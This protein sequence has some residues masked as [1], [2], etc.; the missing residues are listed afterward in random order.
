MNTHVVVRGSDQ[1]M[2]NNDGPAIID[3]NFWD[4]EWSRLGLI[5]ISSNGGAIRMLVPNSLRAAIA[6]MEK[7]TRHVIASYLKNHLVRPD[8]LALEMLF[9]DGSDSPYAFHTPPGTFDRYPVP[10]DSNR[11]W[12]ATV[13]EHKDGRP[14]MRLDLPLYIRTVYNLPCLQPWNSEFPTVFG[15]AR[16]Y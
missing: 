1:L 14:S 9:E 15:V 11:V 13:W 8:Q 5:Y 4:S 16:S 7:G 10:E 6:E 3:T 2:I 12:R